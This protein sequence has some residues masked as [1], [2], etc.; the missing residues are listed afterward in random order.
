MVHK[1]SVI[2]PV[3]NAQRYLKDC[4]DSIIK[5]DYKNIEVILIEDSSQDKSL[6]ICRQYEAEYDNVKVF[7]VCYKSAAK[8]RNYG[9]KKASGEFVVFVDSDDFL[10]DYTVITDMYNVIQNSDTDI[11]VGN[12]LRLWN[13]A[14]YDTAGHK[15]I[16][17]YKPD[18][19][20]FRFEGFFAVG[21]LSYVWAKMYR[22]DF[23]KS[24]AIEF[25][26]ASYAEDKLFNFEC[27]IMGAKYDFLDKAVY[28]YR[29]N[30]AS[31]SNR[32][33]ADSYKTWLKIAEET[34]KMLVI[35]NQQKK[36]GD[37]VAFTIFFAAFFDGKQEYVY[38]GR[39]IKVVSLIL[40]KYAKNPLAHMY[41]VKIAEGMY[42]KE[43]PS[44]MWRVMIRGFAAAM[45]FRMYGLLGLG[46]K[47]LIELK[48][49]EKLSDTGM[50]KA[51]KQNI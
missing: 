42:I 28:V 47:L 43:I 31:V 13:G 37:L 19:A 41:I 10:T 20:A 23:L 35:N 25:K 26:N 6:Q 7:S 3:H 22:T 48:I 16:S 4:M 24:K 40:R 38:K 45:R 9:L 29:K 30:D 33:R 21:T 51:Q 32:Y 1:I 27:Y 5:Q 46:I 34:Y 15:S 14:E 12:Y 39:T 17:I 2:I 44:F 18:T 11:V 49:D 50:K 36:Y 8:T